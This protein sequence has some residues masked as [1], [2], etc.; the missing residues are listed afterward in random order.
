[1]IYL[2]LCLS[3]YLPIYLFIYLSFIY[4]P[5]EYDMK[6][7]DM[8]LLIHVN[9]MFC[10]HVWLMFDCREIYDVVVIL[11]SIMSK[12][13]CQ[14]WTTL[15][16]WQSGKLKL[17]K[18]FWSYHRSSKMKHKCGEPPWLEELHLK[19]GVVLRMYVRLN[20]GVFLVGNH[21]RTWPSEY[22][23]S[24]YEVHSPGG[25]HQLHQR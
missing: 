16:P 17:G 5:C 9:S 25:H 18:T 13:N 21:P 22:F 14:K 3:M 23:P 7:Y 8:S 6:I 4:L 24:T 12:V 1:M 11:I 10:M 2:S 15:L 20:Q 19:N